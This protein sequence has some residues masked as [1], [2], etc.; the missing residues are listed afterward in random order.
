MKQSENVIGTGN[1]AELIDIGDGKAVKLFY[2]GYPVDAVFHEYKNGLA[3]EHALFSHPQVYGMVRMDGR[4]GIVY[5]R[6]VGNT[7]LEYMM[8][9]SDI[10]R[11]AYIMAKTHESL[12]QVRP[13]LELVD[14]RA[15]LRDWAGKRYRQ[16]QDPE[17]SSEAAEAMDRERLQIFAQIE[18]LPAGD[19]LCH[20]DYHPGNVFLCQDGGIAVIDMMNL[21]IGTRLYDVAR[22][23]FLVVLDELPESLRHIQELIM[24]KEMLG[25][26]YLEKMDVT[27]EELTPY[28]EILKATRAGEKG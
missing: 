13:E 27:L 24:A 8:Q 9:T 20:G 15:Q 4:N 5:D 11:C 12:L 26:L 14:Y 6:L 25:S 21:C 10:K 3:I 2:D 28:L 19:T 17:L 16:K 7:L 18:M 23:Y 22:T 1:T